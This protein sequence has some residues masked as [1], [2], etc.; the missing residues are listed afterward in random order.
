[1]FCFKHIKK[2][3]RKSDYCIQV[4]LG[5]SNYS[6]LRNGLAKYKLDLSVSILIFYIHFH[7]GKLSNVE[8]SESKAQTTV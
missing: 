6:T 5:T 2:S 7:Q 4:D 8:L 3:L 1:M